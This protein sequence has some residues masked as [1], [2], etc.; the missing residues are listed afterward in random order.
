M[1]LTWKRQLFVYIRNTGNGH[2][3]RNDYRGL[4]LRVECKCCHGNAAPGI[5]QR[6]WTRYP[7]TSVRLVS[8]EQIERKI[9]ECVTR[10]PRINFLWKRCTQACIHYVST[11]KIILSVVPKLTLSLTQRMG[12]IPNAIGTML[13]FDVDVSA[14]SKQGFSSVQDLAHRYSTDTYSWK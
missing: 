6:T 2:D 9:S 11:S 8:P 14:Q 5:W 13:D 12:Y 3:V 10:S 7:R 1:E 4:R